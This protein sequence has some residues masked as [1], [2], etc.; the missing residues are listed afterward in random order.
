MIGRL[1][2]VVPLRPHA[3]ELPDHPHLTSPQ[4]SHVS[5]GQ[6]GRTRTCLVDL[7][8]AQAARDLATRAAFPVGSAM[9]TGSEEQSRVVDGRCSVEGEAGWVRAK[10]RGGLFYGQTSEMFVSW[11][12]KAKQSHFRGEAIISNSAARKIGAVHLF[13]RRDVTGHP[14]QPS[15]LRCDER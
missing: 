11:S 7:Q 6:V 12:A 5:P 1:S 13:S 3:L 15:P 8:L 10:A 4:A 2:T 9:A 14:A